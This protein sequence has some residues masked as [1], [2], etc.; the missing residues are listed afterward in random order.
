MTAKLPPEYTVADAT[1]VRANPDPEHPDYETF[2]DFA[3]GSHITSWP[4]H[5]DV[6]G[7]VKSGHWVPVKHRKSE[8]D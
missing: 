8:E 1:S 7:W 2:I 6:K 5:A 4:P 3:P